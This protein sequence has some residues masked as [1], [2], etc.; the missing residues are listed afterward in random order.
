MY[1]F[2]VV[3]RKLGRSFLCSSPTHFNRQLRDGIDT[4]TIDDGK[5]GDGGD[6]VEPEKPETRI[7]AVTNCPIFWVCKEP[8]TR[9]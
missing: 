8:P 7:E 6:G 2:V 1:Q 4:S 5:S 3:V 9:L